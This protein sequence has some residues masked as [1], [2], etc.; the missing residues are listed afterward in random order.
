MNYCFV[1]VSQSHER[2][3]VNFNPDVQVMLKFAASSEIFIS[4]L[5]ISKDHDFRIKKNILDF[6]DRKIFTN[7]IFMRGN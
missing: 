5:K 3:F 1:K 7:L 4:L 2:S 6:S